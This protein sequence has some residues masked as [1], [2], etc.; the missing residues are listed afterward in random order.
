MYSYGHGISSVI[1]FYCHIEKTC[2]AEA[3]LSYDWH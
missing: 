1:L 3:L 2:V